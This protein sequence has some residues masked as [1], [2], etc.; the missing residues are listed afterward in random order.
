MGLDYEALELHSDDLGEYRLD[1]VLCRQ[2]SCFCAER[3]PVL[4]GKKPVALCSRNTKGR[5]V[6]TRW[7]KRAEAQ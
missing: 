4:V 1:E 2:C 7:K 5:K 3:Q 6:V